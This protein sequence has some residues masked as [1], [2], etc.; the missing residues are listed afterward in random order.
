M[1]VMSDEQLLELCEA[2]YEGMEESEVHE[3]M[4][5]HLWQWLEDFTDADLEDMYR[6]RVRND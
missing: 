1:V 3:I 2:M 5:E 4:V 6:K